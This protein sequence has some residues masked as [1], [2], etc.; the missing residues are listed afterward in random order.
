MRNFKLCKL[1]NVC[2]CKFHGLL[3]CC[4]LLCERW[5][6]DVVKAAAYEVHHYTTF[7]DDVLLPPAKPLKYTGY[8]LCL[9]CHIALNITFL[10]QIVTDLCECTYH[11]HKMR[12]FF[13]NVLNRMAF[14]M[15]MHCF[16]FG[17]TEFLNVVTE[18][19]FFKDKMKIFSSEPCS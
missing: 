4:G 2:M 1:G 7:I 8:I 17:M 6:S 19:L 16:L 13:H 12:H 9:K 18:F 15:E 10:P 3:G 5:L 14:L 11:C